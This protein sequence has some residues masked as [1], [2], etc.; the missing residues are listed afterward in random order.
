MEKDKIKKIVYE[1]SNT[2]QRIVGKIEN[3]NELELSNDEA[4]KCIEAYSDVLKLYKCLDSTQKLKVNQKVS[5]L[6]AEH[7]ALDTYSDKSVAHYAYDGL[8][9]LNELIKEE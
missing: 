6:Y 1:Y 7:G 9:A 5:E 3:N 4:F 2:I 8:Q